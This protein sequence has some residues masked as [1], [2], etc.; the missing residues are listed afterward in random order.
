MLQHVQNKHGFTLNAQL[1][2][3]ITALTTSYSSEG[4][5][6]PPHRAG[7]CQCITTASRARALPN[8]QKWWFLWTV[9]RVRWPTNTVLEPWRTQ[10][11]LQHTQPLPWAAA[12]PPKAAFQR[13]E[14]LFAVE[15]LNQYTGT[16]ESSNANRSSIQTWNPGNIFACQ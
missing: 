9:G 8:C 6:D 13:A 10:P 12:S 1:L 16:K 14:G 3:W 7:W 4:E 11:W 15:T 5:H 2:S